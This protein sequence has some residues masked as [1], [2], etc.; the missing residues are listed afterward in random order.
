MK[1]GYP[2]HRHFRPGPDLRTNHK[3]KVFKD[4]HTQKHLYTRLDIQTRTYTNIDSQGRLIRADVV[5]LY[6]RG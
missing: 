6:K 4:K 5:S 1:V 3:K 2:E